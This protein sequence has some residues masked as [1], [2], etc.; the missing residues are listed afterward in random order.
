MSD[1][2]IYNGD[3]MIWKKEA[4]TLF[5]SPIIRYQSQ[6][7]EIISRGD[8]ILVDSPRTRRLEEFRHILQGNRKTNFGIHR[9]PKDL[10]EIL[11]KAKE[12]IKV[13]PH[14]DIVIYESVNVRNVFLAFFVNDEWNR[15]F[16]T[17]IL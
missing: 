13:S 1:L 7:H 2:E 15:S 17:Y 14:Y 16:W 8:R 9:L 12:I 4:R 6:T 11:K 5:Y 10:L 3:R